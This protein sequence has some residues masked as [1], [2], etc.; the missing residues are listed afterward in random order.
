M[1]ELDDAKVLKA[2]GATRSDLGSYVAAVERYFEAA[3]F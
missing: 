3:G 1:T 2:V